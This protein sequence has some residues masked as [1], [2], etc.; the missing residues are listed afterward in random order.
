MNAAANCEAKSSYSINVIATDGGN[1]FDTKAVTI[2]VTDVAEK[3][4]ITSG[5]TGTVAENAPISTVVYTATATDPDTTAPNNTISWSLSGT[6][7][8]A[9]RDRKSVE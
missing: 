8:A 4:T 9:F 7:A 5:A 6:D 1:L 3:P 2:S